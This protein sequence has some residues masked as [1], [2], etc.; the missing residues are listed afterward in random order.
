MDDVNNLVITPF[1]EVSEKATE[2]LNNAGENQDMRKAAQKL[3]K[4]G[5]RSLKR[6]EPLC[7]KL[8]N[9]YGDNFLN[10][11]KENSKC[12]YPYAN[13]ASYLSLPICHGSFLARAALLTTARSRNRKLP[14]P[15]QRTTLGL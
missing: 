7:T 3:V 4:E 5:D 12:F 8:H 14:F 2:A 15:T 1:R 6:I 9:D 10:A 13:L 11:L